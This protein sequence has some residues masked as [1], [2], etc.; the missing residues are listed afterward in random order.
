MVA[1]LAMARPRNA[2]QSSSGQI[3]VYGATATAHGCQEGIRHNWHKHE[4]QM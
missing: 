2:T 3:N 4:S 1:P